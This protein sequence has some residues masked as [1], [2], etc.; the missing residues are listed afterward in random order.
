MRDETGAPDLSRA[1]GFAAEIFSSAQSGASAPSSPPPAAEHPAAEPLPSNEELADRLAR[2]FA[3]QQAASAPPS[4]D[5]S[6]TRTQA[7]TRD[8]GAFS[9]FGQIAG[10]LPPI[11]GALSGKTD[12][13]KPE[14]LNLIR[15]FQP[16]LSQTR[17]PE[18][19][20]AIKMANVALAAR[21]AFSA[22]GR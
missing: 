22:L 15:A 9:A 18:I 3:E 10:I 20:R 1:L 21:S 11:L 7:E 12:L 6:D 4:P 17:S 13:V 8:S 16:Y 14:K 5:T 2:L 19:D